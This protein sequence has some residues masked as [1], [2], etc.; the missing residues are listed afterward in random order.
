[1]SQSPAEVPDG[2]YCTVGDLRTGDIRLPAYVDRTQRVKGA[3]EEIDIA[4][5]HIYKTPISFG[6]LPIPLASRPSQLALKKINWLIASGRIL[7]DV[8]AASEDTTNHAYGMGML[9]EGLAMLEKI[10]NGDVL[11]VG[12]QKIEG[13]EENPSFTGPVIMQE[14]P[15]SLVESFYAPRDALGQPI[16]PGTP[17]GYP[18]SIYGVR[19]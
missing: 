4:I 14:D 16:L 18:P 10:R 17:Y 11:L 3:A 1:M 5:G 13:E 19:R 12:A 2:A 6:P 15:V 7:L 8:A 9:K